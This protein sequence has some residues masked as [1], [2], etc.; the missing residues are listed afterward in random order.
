MLP[1]K[2]ALKHSN[3]RS[4]S[5]R[6]NAEEKSIAKKKYFSPLC[7]CSQ[8]RGKEHSRIYPVVEWCRSETHRETKEKT[9]K[10]YEKGKTFA[11]CFFYGYT[12]AKVEQ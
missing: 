3:K 7:C 8:E 6:E 5:Q 2:K 9:R 11:T 1:P 10:K 4:E 12:Q